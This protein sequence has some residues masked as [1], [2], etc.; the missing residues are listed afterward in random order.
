MNNALDASNPVNPLSSH[1][2]ELAVGQLALADAVRGYLDYK[3]GMRNVAASS[4]AAYSARLVRFIRA[5]GASRSLDDAAPAVEGYLLVLAR[6]G[7]SE[8]YRAKVFQ[9]LRDLYRWAC[10]HGHARANPLRD[11]RAPIVHDPD[12]R[13][14]TPAE[15]EQLLDHVRGSSNVHA[16]RDYTLYKTLYGTWARVGAV[17]RSRPED[18]DLAGC[19]V[20]LY[21]KGGKDRVIPFDPQLVSALRAW[22]EH[23][24]RE[25]P[26]MF[27]ARGQSSGGFTVLDRDRV[28]RVLREEYAPAA[29]FGPGVTPHTLRRSAADAARRRGVAIEV[30]QR[31]LGHANITT[32]MKY[33]G[34]PSPDELRGAWKEKGDD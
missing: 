24:P 9:A 10:E 29:G 31:I 30:I 21:E 19:T 26:M 11:H 28:A 25:S 4:A 17:C 6:R 34:V 8:S 23:R 12:R 20:R 3:T 13:F 1:P 14:L 32:T 15:V 16:L 5:V 18:Y 33:L 7:R 22:L 2:A 27:P